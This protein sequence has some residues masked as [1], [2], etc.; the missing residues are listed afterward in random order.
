[1]VT[2][3]IQL[4]ARDSTLGLRPVISHVIIESAERPSNFFEMMFAAV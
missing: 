3:Y 4:G 1:M 2:L